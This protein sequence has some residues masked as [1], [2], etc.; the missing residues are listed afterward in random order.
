MARG[1]LGHATR[2][3]L[4]SRIPAILW[5][6]GMDANL[7]TDTN[8]HYAYSIARR[9]GLCHDEAED[10]AQDVM[11]KAHIYGHDL[12]HPRGWLN[13]CARNASSSRIHQQ[14]RYI[15]LDMLHD[16][17]S[18]DPTPLD[19]ALRSDLIATVRL[20]VDALP[21][22]QRDTLRLI[23]WQDCSLRAERRHDA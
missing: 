22:H 14:A 1:W 23:Y 18:D 7:I 11:L 20:A 5:G 15:P 9:M 8:R 16:Q 13:T 3:E 10:I 6:A 4:Q 19:L 17:P 12:H 21:P 2:R